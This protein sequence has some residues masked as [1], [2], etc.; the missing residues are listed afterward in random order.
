VSYA[1]I[2]ILFFI[3]VKMLLSLCDVHLQSLVSLG[4]IVGALAIGIGAS[5]WKNR[6]T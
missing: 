2:G 6:T 1:V 4:V 3:G 5:M